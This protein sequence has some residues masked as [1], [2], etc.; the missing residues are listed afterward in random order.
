M[1]ARSLD[2]LLEQ[3]RLPE[4]DD[5]GFTEIVIQSIR[6]RRAPLR[7]RRRFVT[8]PAVLAAAA[9]LAT[10]GALAAAVTSTRV[11]NGSHSTAQPAQSKP[12]PHTLASAPASP[13]TATTPATGARVAPAS[14][15]TATPK[16]V[17][18]F[19]NSSYEWGYT[20]AHASYVLDKRTGLRFAID[21]RA[22]SVKA[23]RA[24][25]VTVTLTN[26]TD[27]P[28]GISSQGGCAI[29][30]AAWRGSA[31]NDGRRGGAGR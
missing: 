6:T 14:Q 26:T 11:T 3:A 7:F 4:P 27:K 22:V 19:H 5:D 17:R 28:V 21:T 31:G 24:H 30:V 29:S 13:G 1:S 15:A 10:G 9:V 23:G 8:R 20:S 12:S 16:V 2:Q 18:T 25:D